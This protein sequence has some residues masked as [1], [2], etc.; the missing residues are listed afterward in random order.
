MASATLTANTSAGAFTV[1]AAVSGVNTPASFS[2]TN[3]AG[4]APWA[5][6]DTVN[7]KIQASLPSGVSNAANGLATGTH[8]ITWEAQNN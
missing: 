8:A 6:T 1:T 2:L 4:A 7:Y 5:N 3:Q